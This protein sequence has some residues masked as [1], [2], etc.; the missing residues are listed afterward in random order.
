LNQQLQHEITE[1]ERFDQ[2]FK[3][4]SSTVAHD[5]KGRSERFWG[6]AELDCRSAEQAALPKLSAW[7]DELVN[8]VVKVGKIVDALLLLAKVRQQDV[9]V[10]RLEMGAIVGRSRKTFGRPDCEYTG[11]N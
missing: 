11:S 4:F 8:S 5:I 2:R 9:A 10:S 7:G 3:S 6:Y 1:H